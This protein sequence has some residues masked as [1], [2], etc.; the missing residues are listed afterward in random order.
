LTKI[1]LQVE[2]SSEYEME[3]DGGSKNVGKSNNKQEEPKL[4][5]KSHSSFE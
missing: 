2:K 5:E 3:R 1:V 4:L